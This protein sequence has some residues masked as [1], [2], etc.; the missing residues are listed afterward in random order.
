MTLSADSLKANLGTPQRTYLFNVIIPNFPGLMGDTDTLMLRCQSTTL[1]SRSVSIL[2]VNYKQAPKLQYPGKLIYTHDWDCTFI[3]GEDAAVFQTF[4][5]WA[6]T[7]INDLTN[8]GGTSEEIKTDIILQLV[9]TADE[10]TLRIRLKGCFIKD[11]QG[12]SLAYNTEGTL[13]LPV[14]LRYDSWVMD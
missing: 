2:E 12:A 10:E 7:V 9:S 4:Y 3:E 11:M 5:A 1:P 8:Q 13:Q 14:T 6:Q